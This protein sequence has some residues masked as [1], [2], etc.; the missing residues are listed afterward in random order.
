MYNCLLKLC[1]V[2]YTI[3]LSNLL[4]YPHQSCVVPT[5]QIALNTSDVYYVTGS[6]LVL[7]CEL[8]LLSENID[9]TTIANFQW[10]ND[11]YDA[12]LTNE[13]ILRDSMDET[14]VIYTSFFQFTNLKLSDAGNYTCIGSI[15][16]VNSSFIIQSSKTIDSGSVFIKSKY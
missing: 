7:R 14:K 4:L 12:V 11:N 10:K 1:I 13:S 16:V 15:D 2:V 9:I 5:P 8:M 3:T 6:S